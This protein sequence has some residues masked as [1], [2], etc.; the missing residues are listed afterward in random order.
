MFQHK[1]HADNGDKPEIPNANGVVRAAGDKGPRRQD[2]LRLA[3]GHGRVDLQ[4][5]D[6]RG[7]EDEG[8][9]LAHLKFGQNPRLIMERN[10]KLQ[11]KHWAEKAVLSNANLSPKG[12]VNLVS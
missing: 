12:C 3:V 11:K 8:V 2:G 6:A 5:P 4:P 1:A 10:P 9:R 7:V